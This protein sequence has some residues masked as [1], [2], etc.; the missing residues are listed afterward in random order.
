[1]K[2]PSKAIAA[3]SRRRRHGFSLNELGPQRWRWHP[4]GHWLL[5]L[6]MLLISNSVPVEAAEGYYRFVKRCAR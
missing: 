3:I 5:L 1:M 6:I 2:R 4:N